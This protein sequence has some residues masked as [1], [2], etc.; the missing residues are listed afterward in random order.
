MLKLLAKKGKGKKESDTP[1]EFAN[2]IVIPEVNTV[3]WFYYN[4]RFGNHALTSDERE[5]IADCLKKIKSEKV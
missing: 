3:T 2:T 4:T 1:F 5:K